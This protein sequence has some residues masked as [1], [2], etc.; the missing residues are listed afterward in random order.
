MAKGQVGRRV[1]VCVCV[2]H[3][4]HVFEWMCAGAAVRQGM[5]R[6]VPRRGNVCSR[7]AHGELPREGAKLSLDG[8]ADPK[9]E[10]WS[11]EGF[12]IVMRIM[13]LY[14]GKMTRCG[15][16][17]HLPGRRGRGIAMPA[18]CAYHVCSLAQDLGCPATALRPDAESRRWK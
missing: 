15:R 9:K 13:E 2:C 18:Q 17:T 4:A 16:G 5:N 11:G 10:T 6:G 8:S 1:L 14:V 7:G 3:R 12:I